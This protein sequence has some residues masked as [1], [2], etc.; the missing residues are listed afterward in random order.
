MKKIFYKFLIWYFEK[1]EFKKAESIVL[2][3]NN[4]TIIS[5]LKSNIEHIKGV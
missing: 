1:I 4:F 2:Q 3:Q 5:L